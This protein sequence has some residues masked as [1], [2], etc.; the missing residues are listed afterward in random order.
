[1]SNFSETESNSESSNHAR[2]DF[3]SQ[4][5]DSSE[6]K[7]SG[8]Q[9]R[10][11]NYQPNSK[12]HYI[13]SKDPKLSSQSTKFNN[14]NLKNP[15]KVPEETEPEKPY[16]ST[17]K[18][19]RITDISYHQSNIYA[20]EKSDKSEIFDKSDKSDDQNQNEYEY[21]DN[22]GPTVNDV[23]NE[24]KKPDVVKKPENSSN[25]EYDYLYYYY[26]DYVYPEDE[27]SKDEELPNPSY[28]ISSKSGE[29][30]TTESSLDYDDDSTTTVFPSDTNNA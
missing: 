25:P 12:N 8:L 23:T 15:E 10:S 24:V 5:P 17:E 26:Y 7:Y 27:K 6:R 28:L 11:A 30:I 20:D 19:D 9:N 21:V 3:E 14:H 16:T 22:E 2:A 13:P 4:I 1:M 18:T 29:L